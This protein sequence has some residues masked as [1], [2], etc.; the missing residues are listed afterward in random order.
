M[1]PLQRLEAKIKNRESGEVVRGAGPSESEVQNRSE[2]RQILRAEPIVE[3]VAISGEDLLFNNTIFDVTR[4]HRPDKRHLNISNMSAKRKRSIETKQSSKVI[5]RFRATAKKTKALSLLK[6]G[7]SAVIQVEESGKCYKINIGYEFFCSC[8]HNQ[9]SDRKVCH[10]I[11]WCYTKLANK[12]LTDPITVQVQLS[13]TE[14]NIP[15]EIPTDLLVCDNNDKRDFHQKLKNHPR[16]SATNDWYVDIK[17]SKKGCRCSGCLGHDKIKTGDLHLN[18]KGLIYLQKHDKVVE[19]TLRFC[20]RK[21]CVTN[22]K[23]EYHNIQDMKDMVCKKKAESRLSHE[24]RANLHL[25]GFK[26][27]GLGSI[28]FD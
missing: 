13:D 20:P 6:N 14:L 7:D 3:S 1:L 5:R 10:H 24:Q 21:A 4:S 12:E 16:F 15:S 22:V 9:R 27:S 17:Q 19:A 18:V 23:S 25:E 11:L 26:V 8:T 2:R 28:S